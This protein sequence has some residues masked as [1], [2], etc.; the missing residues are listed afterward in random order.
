VAPCKDK[1]GQKKG[2]DYGDWSS[3]VAM[4]VTAFL[5]KQGA[6]PPL[7]LTIAQAITAAV[8]VGRSAQRALLAP[9][10]MISME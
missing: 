6:A 7:P 5:R 3:A 1:K 2:E 9:C 4:A 8:E 10:Q